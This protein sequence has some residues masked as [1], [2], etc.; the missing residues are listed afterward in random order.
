MLPGILEEFPGGLTCS[1][2]A[3]PSEGCAVPAQE[4]GAWLRTVASGELEWGQQLQFWL[5]VWERCW[6]QK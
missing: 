3:E 6:T 2:K 4:G 1:E 5:L